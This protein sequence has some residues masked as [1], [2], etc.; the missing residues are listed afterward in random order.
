[1]RRLLQLITAVCLL[2]SLASPALQAQSRAANQ[3]RITLSP[4]VS[5]PT[6]SAGQTAR[7]KIIII[8]D[9]TTDY[10]F[11][12]YARPFSVKGEQYDPNYTEVNKRTEAYQWLQ[13]DRTQFDLAA[14]ERIEVGYT[15]KVPKDAAGGGHYAVLFAETQPPQDGANVARKKRVGSLLYMSVAG[16]VINNG[17]LASWQTPFFQPKRPVNATARIKNDGN[18]HFQA[19]L[20]VRFSNIFNKKQFE[21]NQELLI[22]PG[23]TRRVVVSWERAPY[24]GLFKASGSVKYL[25]KIEQL[26]TKYV[27]LLPY[28]IIIFL[29]ALVAAVVTRKFIRRNK[30]KRTGSSRGF[31]R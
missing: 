20:S 11:L 22:L 18:V 5:R 1:M 8:N 14:G 19:D 7:G 6:L 4:A 17:S 3:E 25:N 13:L 12:L 27:L 15:L 9:G 16:D 26:P 31:K 28:P 29:L 2:F 21:L 10:K 30:Q 24:F 23:T